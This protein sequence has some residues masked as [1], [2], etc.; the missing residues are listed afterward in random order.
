MK[1]KPKLKNMLIATGS[2]IILTLIQLFGNRNMPS[3]LSY[4][5]VLELLILWLVV[6]ICWII[7]LFRCL[8][9]KKEDEPWN[10]KE[11]DPW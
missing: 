2:C 4:R 9:A 8:K 6:A 7:Y 5:N 3:Y 1:N 11:K 10:K